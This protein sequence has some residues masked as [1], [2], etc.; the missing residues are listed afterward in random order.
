MAKWKRLVLFS[1]LSRRELDQVLPRTGEEEDPPTLA[2]Q[3]LL[4][5]AV[6]RG[7]QD[8]SSPRHRA[9]LALRYGLL[10]S[11]CH[12]LDELTRLLGRYRREYVS[13]C[14]HAAL[15]RLRNALLRRRA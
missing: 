13:A 6:T 1:D 8:L 7:L 9:V 2:D 4:A 3:A 14:Q 11:D 15:H 12:S 10:G 5:E